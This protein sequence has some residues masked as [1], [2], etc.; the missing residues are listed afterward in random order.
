MILK[1]YAQAETAFK[2]VVN[3]GE[4]F[5]LE[6]YAAVFNP[7]NKNSS[8]SVMEVQYKEGSEGCASNYVM[9]FLPQPMSAEDVTAMLAMYNVM[10]ASVQAVTVE[11]YNIPTP[12]LI[13]AYE[14]GTEQKAASVG[15]VTTNGTTY[16]FIF[17][18]L[19]PHA[20]FG[21]TNDKFPVCRYAEVLLFL[22]EVLN[23]QGKLSEALPYLNRVRNRAG[24]NDV[25]TTGQDEL[26][27]IILH[28]RRVE[29]VFENKRWTVLVG[30]GKAVEVIAAYGARVKVQ[31]ENYYYPASQ[32]P[33]PAAF[34][35]IDLN[36]A[37]PASEALLSPCFQC[38]NER[39][40]DVESSV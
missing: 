2:A 36:F 17:K 14:A 5:L 16:P 30:T 7:A 34:F 31:P 8:E 11:A 35:N 25:M 19:H 4:Y 38:R 6:D 32:A 22:A 33:P 20:L 12:D 40:D 24:L 21:N 28:E 26:G 18:Y 3:S 9:P 15:Y 10:P 1:Q 39:G 27:D 29:L 13:G 23:E 37:L